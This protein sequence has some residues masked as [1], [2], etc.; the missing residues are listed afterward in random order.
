MPTTSPTG[1][2]PD[3]TIKD[4]A[5]HLGV[6]HATV[7]RALN[8]HPATSAATKAS[9]RAAAE[10]LGY[11]R[12]ASAGTLSG[13]SSRMIGFIAP[14]V[15]N[16]FYA[17]I[18]KVL[19]AA[20]AQI[21]L[22]LVLAVSE[23]D[24]ELEY[25]HV[26]ALREARA[27]GVVITATAGLLPKTANLLAPLPAIQ[28]VR[29]NPMLDKRWV[30]INDRTGILLAT[31]HLL[32]L[33]HER[34]GFIGG[35]EALTT[36]HERLGG[37]TDALKASGVAVDP[38]LVALGPPRPSFG[39]E[40]ALRLTALEKPITGLVLGSSQ[41]TMGAL[42]ALQ[43]RHLSAPDPI[44]IVGYSDPEWFRLWG[45]GL[46]TVSLPTEQIATTAAQML[47]RAIDGR[48]DASGQGGVA[49]QPQLVERG[50]A[51]APQSRK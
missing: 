6:S 27:A 11:I 28:L 26:L 2:R 30:G 32:E 45:Q 47:F 15:Q 48:P 25:R 43:Q 36:G 40:A 35:Y 12:N 37:Y 16:D 44:S 4:I 23:D 14:D 34:I 18:T 21:G 39:L 3:V 41:L 29:S 1:P 31:R 24:P 9:V 51:A 33:G 20:C 19:A 7:S 49:F 46:T 8:D 22:Q 13:A 42:G 5:A 50:S 38:E 17:T 10:A